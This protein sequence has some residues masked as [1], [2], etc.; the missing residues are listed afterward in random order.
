MVGGTKLPPQ[1]SVSEPGC[2]ERKTRATARTKA[3]TLYEGKRQ[4][5]S[6]VYVSLD[7]ADTVIDGW[8]TLSRC[9]KRSRSKLGCPTLVRAFCGQGGRR[10]E[11]QQCL[12]FAPRCHWRLDLDNSVDPCDVMPVAAP[13]PIFR[14][15]NQAAPYGITMKVFQ[16]LNALLCAPHIEVVIT[17]LPKVNSWGNSVRHVLLEHLE[18]GGPHIPW[19]TIAFGWQ[20]WGFAP[21]LSSRI[22]PD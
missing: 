9:D 5:P 18:A 16:F 2:Y 15:L 22:C 21:M 11:G 12:S 6:Q 1:D 20:L 19:P 10:I 8:P 3:K 13:L 14:L 7:N 4:K 17:R